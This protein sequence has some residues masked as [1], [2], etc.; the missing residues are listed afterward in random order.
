VELSELSA[1]LLLLLY[2]GQQ[3]LKRRFEM[4]FVVDEQDILPQEPCL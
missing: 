4:G 2:F 3:A 1:P